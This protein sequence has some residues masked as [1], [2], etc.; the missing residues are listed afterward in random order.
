MMPFRES[1]RELHSRPRSP[2]HNM[3]ITPSL[4]VGI[5]FAVLLLVLFLRVRAKGGILPP[6][7]FAYGTALTDS[8]AIPERMNQFLSLEVMDSNEVK[9]QTF[10][11]NGS[12][13]ESHAIDYLHFISKGSRLCAVGGCFEERRPVVGS[14]R[15]GDSTRQ[16]ASPVQRCVKKQIATGLY[17]RFC[18]LRVE[19]TIHAISSHQSKGQ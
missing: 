1:Q 17:Y 12:R 18:L 19:T 10:V 8:G 3:K 5:L 14:K 13:K 11:G 6:H 7:E 4:I 9:I 16:N 2:A 15:K